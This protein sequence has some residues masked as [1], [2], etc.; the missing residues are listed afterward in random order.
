VSGRPTRSI[1][2]TAQHHDLVAIVV[3]APLSDAGG[4]ARTIFRGATVTLN[5]R[6]FFDVSGTESGISCYGGC[7]MVRLTFETKVC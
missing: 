7:Y 3:A 6:F 2:R 1:Q 4:R 5:R